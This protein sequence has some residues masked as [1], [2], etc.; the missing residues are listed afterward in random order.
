M[1]S[2]TDREYA[3]QIERIQSELADLQQNRRIV[4]TPAAL[5]Q[6]E[7]DIRQLTD[8]LAAAILDQK[9]QESL[10]SD[11]LAE[12]ERTLIKNHPKRLKSEGKKSGH[13]PHLLRR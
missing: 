10:D 13:H 7:R 3:S 12:A 11:E 5:E 9:V 1:Q 6:L 2:N 4:T 8:R